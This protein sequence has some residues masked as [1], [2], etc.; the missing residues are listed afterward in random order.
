MTMSSPSESDLP[1]DPDTPD[2]PET[3]SDLTPPR[4][5]P[6]VEFLLLPFFWLAPL[7]VV[8][9]GYAMSKD[10][11]HLK[12]R[13]DI[14]LPDTRY[15]FYLLPFTLSYLASFVWRVQRRNWIVKRLGFDQSAFVRARKAHK[16]GRMRVPVVAVAVVQILAFVVLALVPDGVGLQAL[17]EGATWSFVLAWGVS[18]FVVAYDAYTLQRVPH[19]DWSRWR[20]A[21]ALASA[22]PFVAFVYLVKRDDHVWFATVVEHWTTD[23]AEFNI[24]ESEKST[25]ERLTDRLNV[26]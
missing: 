2:V 20:Y 22:L 12:R 11:T 26:M 23:P 21:Y 15:L 17:I 7:M 8:G 1:D 19:V 10:T 9:L 25:L 16:V 13:Y 5:L 18:P 4:T 14:S 3:S 6:L 24:D